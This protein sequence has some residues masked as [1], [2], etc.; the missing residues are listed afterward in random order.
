[1]FFHTQMWDYFF[2]PWIDYDSV[3]NYMGTSYGENGDT[4]DGYIV[5]LGAG[6]SDYELDMIFD[7]ATRVNTTVEI[8]MSEG[9]Y[10]TG[11]L[12]LV[13]NET[14]GE[15]LGAYQAVIRGDI[16]GD[17]Y[18]DTSDSDMISMD[19]AYM[20]DW[21][22]GSDG[23]NCSYRAMAADVSGDAWYDEADCNVIAMY[24]A[25]QADIDQETG[26]TILY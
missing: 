7:P 10:G 12:I 1:M 22:W 6:I 13:K 16:N 9:G 23:S 8:E 25:Y 20:T 17:A 15:I 11:T 21:K 5:G 2:A 18:I 3:W 24:G 4:L 14:T 26:E 19:L